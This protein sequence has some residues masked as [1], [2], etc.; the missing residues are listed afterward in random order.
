[1]SCVYCSVLSYSFR[2]SYLEVLVKHIDPSQAFLGK[3]CTVIEPSSA[4]PQ[5][6]V[7]RF[8]DGTSAEADVVLIANGINSNF[9]EIVTGNRSNKDMSYSGATCYRGLVVK[10]KAEQKGVDTSSWKVV[11]CAMGINK[12]SIQRIQEGLG[13]MA[14]RVLLFTQYEAGAWC[15]CI[16]HEHILP[17]LKGV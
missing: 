11:S 15:V 2:A 14:L 9:R 7:I 4:N 10:E 16:Y 8:K 6:S 13:L 3:R 17:A 1:M 12:V 5:R